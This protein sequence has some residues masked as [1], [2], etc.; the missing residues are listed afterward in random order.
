MADY[1]IDIDADGIAVLTFTRPGRLNPISPDAFKALPADLDRIAKDPAI[2]ALIFTGE[3]RAFCSGA[4][5]E[6][7]AGDLGKGP[8]GG[9]PSD[10]LTELFDKGV[11]LIQRQLS[12][13]EKPVIMAV[14]GIAAGGGV[15]LALAGDVVLASDTASFHLTFFPNLG[16]LPDFGSSWL[17]PRLLGRGRAMAAMVTGEPIDAQTA[18]E[19]GLVWKLVPQTDLMDT[20]RDYA[21]KLAN[22]PKS[23]LPDLRRAADLASTH[24]FSP[25]LDLERDVN[26]K[27]CGRASF[28]EGVTAFLEKRRPDFG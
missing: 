15:G 9:I 18:L 20:A 7:L 8:E 6:T 23:A 2:R 11:N 10:G 28:T 16:I 1:T 4:S 12:E 3:G 26:L 22:G 25:H 13:M 21:R 17:I 5:L 19:W 27:L 24:D 14:N